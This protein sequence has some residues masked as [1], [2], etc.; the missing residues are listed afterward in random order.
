MQF[1]QAVAATLAGATLILT[2]LPV[3]AQSGVVNVYSYR[4]PGLIQPLLDRFTEET[5]ITSNV[6]FAG[7]GLIERVAAEGELSPAGVIITVD[8]S[9]LANDKELGISQPI[10]IAALERVPDAY[11]DPDGHWVALSLR[12]RVF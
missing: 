2:G 8:I 5:G 3:Q 7:D 4:E 1:S 6:L 9:N 10:P 11:H 12:A